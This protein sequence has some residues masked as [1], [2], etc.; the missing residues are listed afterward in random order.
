[1][2]GAQQNNYIDQLIAEFKTKINVGTQ[3]D[4]KELAGKSLVTYLHNANTWSGGINPATRTTFFRADAVANISMVTDENNWYFTGENQGESTNDIPAVQNAVIFNSA[5]GAVD[6]RKGIKNY[7]DEFFAAAQP[8]HGLSYSVSSLLETT[9]P[10]TT[11]PGLAMNLTDLSQLV[12][13]ES[14]KSDIAGNS[15]SYT[16]LYNSIGDSIVLR[17]SAFNVVHDIFEP[18]FP[19]LADLSVSIVKADST[20]VTLSLGTN[21]TVLMPN[22]IV[23]DPATS[24]T[25]STGDHIEVHYRYDTA[26]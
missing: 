8:S 18:L 10:A 4:G 2:S 5:S 26:H 7:L 20:R 1:M 6:A 21:Y 24:N 25:T 9:K 11:V 16:N 23:L 13:R 17:A 22:G 3:G 15:T 12:G 19:T 14:A